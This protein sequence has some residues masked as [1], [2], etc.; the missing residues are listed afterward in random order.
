M[1]VQIYLQ[2]LAKWY[3]A[4][5]S[6]KPF[7]TVFGLTSGF[8]TLPSWKEHVR[9]SWVQSCLYL[10]QWHWYGLL[11]HDRHLNG[12][13]ERKNNVVNWHWTAV[14]IPE[15]RGSI[16]LLT[17]V[18]KTN[19][20]SLKINASFSINIRGLELLEAMLK[21]DMDLRLVHATVVENKTGVCECQ[22]RLFGLE[23]E[24]HDL[25]VTYR[26]QIIAQ[27]N[28]LIHGCFLFW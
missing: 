2:I 3:I 14:N 15:N 21:L 28:G 10:H 19:S 20:N 5:S 6:V 8:L 9:G 13:G 1:P 12:R 25:V 23:I 24:L 22:A 7:S 18:F 17:Y 16:C 27:I 4:W 26:K 11:T